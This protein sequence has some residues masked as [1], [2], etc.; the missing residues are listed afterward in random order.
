MRC[1][2]AIVDGMRFLDTNVLLYSVSLDPRDTGKRDQAIALL[3][4]DDI[5]LSA[6]VLQEFYVQATRPSRHDPLPHADAVDLIDAWSRFPI[7]DITLPILFLPLRGLIIRSFDKENIRT[8]EA[9]K[10][11]A[12]THP[13]SIADEQPA[14]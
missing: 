6:Q 3:E 14:A 1:T 13:G 2:N 11:Y 10:K 5:A 8:M 12:E 9:V 7:Q 4:C